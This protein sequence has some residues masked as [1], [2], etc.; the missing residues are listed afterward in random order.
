[1]PDLRE[2]IERLEED[3]L[4]CLAEADDATLMPTSRYAMVGIAQGLEHALSAL[5]PLLEKNDG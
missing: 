1:M 5:K 4:K 3:R 2:V